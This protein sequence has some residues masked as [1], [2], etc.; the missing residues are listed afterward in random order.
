MKQD[1]SARMREDI[2][3]YGWHCVQIAQDAKG[4][5]Y[6][7]T[8]GLLETHQHPELVVMG[9]PPEVAHTILG[10][11]VEQI[12]QGYKF[13]ESQRSDALLE[14]HD[15][16]LHRVS[17][18]AYR[19]YLALAVERHR[20]APTGFAALQILWPDPEGRFPEE[21]GYSHGSLQFLL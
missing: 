11:A 21:E 15:C 3:R 4:P 18:T 14:G 5:G 9:L 19:A 2:Q 17:P 8:V 1:I 7:F 6:S 10:M 20:D 12:A 13:F 16:L